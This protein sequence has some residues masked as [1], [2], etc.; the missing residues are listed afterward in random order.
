MGF[1]W[2]NAPTKKEL[3][4]HLIVRDAMASKQYGSVRCVPGSRVLSPVHVE[5]RI[6]GRVCNPSDIDVDATGLYAH[7]VSPGTE[8]TVSLTDRTGAT[9]TASVIVQVIHLPVV[10]EYVSTPASSER[11]RDGVVEVMVLRA[12]EG[13]LYLWSNGIVT[14]QPILHNVT[15]G[16]YA[17]TIITAEHTMVLH[18]NA[19]GPARVGV[20]PR[21]L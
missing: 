15:P 5:W 8:C 16:M 2:R 10:T 12:P 3:A 4:F 6:D 13:C 9:E 14:R 1:G 7:R 19:A 17:A 11:A 21:G 20:L 18:V